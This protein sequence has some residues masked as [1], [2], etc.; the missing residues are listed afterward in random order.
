MNDEV[1]VQIKQHRL[2]LE[3]N[4][5]EGASVNWSESNLSAANLQ[6]VDLKDANLS[7]ANLQNAN[8]RSANLSFADLSD[9]D[10]SHADLSYANL[11]YA[12]LSHAD[13]SQVNLHFAIG[14]M[15]EVKS[16]H[17]ELFSAVWYCDA[18]GEIMVCIGCERKSLKEWKTIDRDAAVVKKGDPEVWERTIPILWQLIE[19]SPPVPWK[20]E[21]E[22]ATARA[23]ATKVPINPSPSPSPSP[24]PRPRPR[25]PV[26]T[27]K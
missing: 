14:N 27:T 20:V 22:T 6:N 16:T 8:L 5:E 10:L 2:W 7:A 24:S 13:L 15:R 4:G 26:L 3:S 25:P 9:A 18:A 17:F 12:N 19:A 23:A 21:S 1:K 11:S